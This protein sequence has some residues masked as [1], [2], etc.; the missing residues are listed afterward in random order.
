MIAQISGD[1][2]EREF[3]IWC[4]HHGRKLPA[5]SLMQRYYDMCSYLTA[6]QI[7]SA[8]N[9]A[10]ADAVFFKD[11][12]TYILKNKP[13]NLDREEREDRANK[14]FEAEFTA[15]ESK[16]F[17]YAMAMASRAYVETLNGKEYF[18]R[19]WDFEPLDHTPKPP[20]PPANSGRPKQNEPE[21]VSKILTLP[22]DTT[23]ASGFNDDD[24][25]DNL[26]GSDNE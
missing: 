23:R 6:E 5:Q 21:P 9:S 19:Y 11:G 10:I 14:L 3:L 16:G 17:E 18:R 22:M 26:F 12:L 7:R 2:F 25:F 13:V 24:E 1:A 20:K 4:E 8:I 15:L